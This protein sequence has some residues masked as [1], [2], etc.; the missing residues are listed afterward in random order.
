MIK[1][2]KYLSDLLFGKRDSITSQRYFVRL[3]TF[4]AAIFSLN[5]GFFH[6]LSSLNSDAAI[7]ALTTACLLFVLYAA[8]RFFSFLLVPKIVLT[9][10]GLVILDVAFYIKYLSNG[11]ILL[12]ILIFSALI[13]LLW[14]GKAL[15]LLLVFYFLNL[16]VLFYIDYTAATALFEYPSE[17]QRSID[18]FTSFFIYT[19]LLVSLLYIFKLDFLEQKKKAIQSDKLKSAFLAN[20]SHEIRTPMNG[21]LGF[22]DLLRN[23]NL[24]GTKQQ[25]YIEIIDKSGH[26]MLNVINDIIDISQIESGLLKATMKPVSI[27]KQLG[28]LHTLF[29]KDV[30]AKGMQLRCL[31]IEETEEVVVITDEAKLLAI[32]SNLIKNAI[33]YSK[34]GAIEFGYVVKGNCLEFYVKDNGIGIVTERQN[35]I[36]E[37][38][39]Q[40]DIDDV[41]ARQGAGLGLSITKA[42]VELLGGN[43]W[44]ESE[45]GAG[46]KFSFSIPI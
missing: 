7:L 40:A 25:E 29:K 37:R 41:Q 23:P 26:R 43:I 46:S 6:I 31:N 35:A 14:D 1:K 13:L 30:E 16:C 21:I 44:V 20:M 8:V 36:F 10:G 4:I 17:Q 24:S 18:I 12:F 34:Q 22:S 3:A 27:H 15:M 19:M 33:K 32:L 2:T 11:P 45:F 5:L 39:V 9:I 42:Y 38:F 28:Y